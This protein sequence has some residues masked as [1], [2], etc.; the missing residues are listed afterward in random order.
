M[1]KTS[2]NIYSGTY[3]NIFVLDD[4]RWY[5]SMLQ[6]FLLLNPEYHVER[7]ETAKELLSQLYRRPNVITID[8]SMP[9]MDGSAVLKKI[10]QELPET[11]VIIISG[12]HDIKTAIALLK[13]GA[14][15]YIVKD[16]ETTDRLWNALQN[17]RRMQKLE[18]KVSTLQQEV[19][20]KY[21]FGNTV[22]GN[23]KA[24]QQVFTLMQKASE[25]SITVSIY[26]ETGSGKE[27]IAKA[28]HYNSNRSKHPFV[29]L[30]VA[31]IPAD[32]VE[33]ELFGYE[34]GAFTGAVARRIGKFEEADKGTLFLDEIGELDITVQAK[35]L[36]ALQ[37]R[38]IC[39]LGGNKEIPVDVRIIVATHCNLYDLMVKKQFREDLYY[40]LLG[41]TVDLPPLRERGH[42]IVLLA[43]HFMQVFCKQNNYPS[44]QL[45]E[46]ALKKLLLYPFPGNVRE[47]KSIVELAVVLSSN[48]VIE[49]SDLTLRIA[50]NR[51]ITTEKEKSLEEY[52]WEIID[53]YLKRYHGNVQMVANK[54]EVGKSTI[55]RM[56]KA[57]SA[58]N[59]REWLVHNNTNFFINK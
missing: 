9:E 45:S 4:E 39:R 21:S 40:R 42:D 48:T 34:K 12:Q 49:A 23:G 14:Y 20:K 3:Y 2:S 19:E 43:Q 57:R 51:D 1:A 22:I 35:L 24:M 36:R 47:L 58:K 29:A 13:E 11:A 30:N 50:D 53:S 38:I 27:V 8:F 56:L 17:I 33:S 55:Y 10:R 44:K 16:K 28:I 6:N 18:A 5:G 54:L 41:L 25:S 52:E 46:A 15:D 37:E 31:A 26:G 32:L 59:T 7:F